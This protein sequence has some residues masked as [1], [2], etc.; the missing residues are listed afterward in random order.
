MPIL[1]LQKDVP[2]QR[3]WIWVTLTLLIGI[4]ITIFRKKNN[5]EV[6]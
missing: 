6:K 2:Q 5:N 3:F 4:S 1:I